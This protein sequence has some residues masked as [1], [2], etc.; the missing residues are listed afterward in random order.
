MLKTLAIG[1]FGRQR[2]SDIFG[3]AQR[4]A[5]EC[6]HSDVTIQLLI[7][8]QVDC[9]KTLYLGLYGQVTKRIRWMPWQSEAMKDVVACDK[10]R[11]GSKRPLIRRFPN[12]ATQPA[13]GLSCTEYIGVGSERGELKHLS[14]LR[15]RN[16]LRFR[17]QRRAKADQPLSLSCVSGR[18]W[19]VPPQWVIAPYTKALDR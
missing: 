13:C 18:F 7:W 3:M 16:Q 5:T 4:L 6:S 19:K 10:L 1:F 12:G 2:S 15:N 11:G 14:T 8:L 9:W 17:Q